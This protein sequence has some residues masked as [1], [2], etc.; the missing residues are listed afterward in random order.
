SASGCLL[1][2]GVLA[3]HPPDA[4]SLRG[5][6]SRS[7]PRFSSG[8]WRR[9]PLTPLAVVA[10][11]LV[12]ASRG[13]SAACPRGLWATSAPDGGAESALSRECVRWHGACFRFRSEV[14]PGWPPREHSCWLEARLRW[15]RRW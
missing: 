1:S 10:V 2:W 8:C 4:P 11:V 3:A 15:P 6:E 7:A 5:S 13:L 9:A 14:C 12:K